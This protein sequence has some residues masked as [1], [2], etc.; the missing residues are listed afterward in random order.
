M[1]AVKQDIFRENT[2]ELVINGGRKFQAV[3]N[4]RKCVIYND[5]CCLHI[6]PLK[7]A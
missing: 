2:V 7:L 3:L 6:Y 5:L 1:I 4:K